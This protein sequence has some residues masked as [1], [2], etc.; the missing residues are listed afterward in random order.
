LQLPP[1]L[2]FPLRDMRLPPGRVRIETN[3]LPPLKHRTNLSVHL[4]SVRSPPAS[5]KP[6]RLLPHPNLKQMPIR[7]PTPHKGSR[8]RLTPV[9]PPRTV[10]PDHNPITVRNKLVNL[11]DSPPIRGSNPR[12]RRVSDLIQKVRPGRLRIRIRLPNLRHNRTKIHMPRRT[13]RI[14]Q[15]APIRMPRRIPV[16]KPETRHQRPLVSHIS[17][18]RRLTV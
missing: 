7:H 11:R 1:I 18:R 2:S 10:E 13:R 12:I 17:V 3:H 5:S 4:D 8:I 16:R 9:T 14:M 15:H 6:R